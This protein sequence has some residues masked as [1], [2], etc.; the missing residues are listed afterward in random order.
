M[1]NSLD[2]LARTFEFVLLEARKWANSI[3]SGFSNETGNVWFER[4]E[5]E[6]GETK[7]EFCGAPKTV[8]IEIGRENYAYAF[9]HTKNI[10]DFIAEIFEDDMQFDVIIGNPPYQMRGGAGGSRTLLFITCLLSRQKTWS[11]SILQWLFHQ[12]GSPVDVDST[13]LEQCWF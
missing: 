7:C 3:A 10:K 5:H 12:D 6:W 1:L 9:I 8:L 4:I 11:Q 13:T 2:R